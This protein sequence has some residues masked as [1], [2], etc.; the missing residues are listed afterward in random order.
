MEAGV[1]DRAAEREIL[2]HFGETLAAE[3][4]ARLGVADLGRGNAER[5]T[6]FVRR[7]SIF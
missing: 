4:A 5:P 1:L 6:G 2:L 7:P 3:S